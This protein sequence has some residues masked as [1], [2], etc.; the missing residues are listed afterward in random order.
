MDVYKNNWS[1][2]QEP[3]TGSVIVFN[4][5]GEP[6]HV[7]VYIGDDKFIHARDGMD[8]VIE[9]VNS[10]RWNKRIEGYYKYATQPQIQL[11][12]KPH[13]FKETAYSELTIPGSTLADISQNLITTYKISDYFAKNLLIFLDGVKVPKSEWDSVRVQ[14]GQQIVYKVV[15]DDEES[16][17]FAQLEA[18][19]KDAFSH[20]PVQKSNSFR[21]YSFLKQMYFVDYEPIS[22]VNISLIEIKELYKPNEKTYT[23]QFLEHTSPPPEFLVIS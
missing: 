14:A 15:C 2:V 3:E 22:F 9:S 20:D 7:G 6:F 23:N 13:P 17:L 19:L 12:G 11:T 16:V 4:I 8:S 1:Q 21:F 10:P 18:D 5:L